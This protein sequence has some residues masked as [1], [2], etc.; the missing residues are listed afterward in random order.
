MMD[1]R[2]F[3]AW[4]MAVYWAL[5]GVKD[6]QLILRLIQEPLGVGN[7][8][9]V[10]GGAVATVVIAGLDVGGVPGA[11]VVGGDG[12]GAQVLGNHVLVPPCP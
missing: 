6:C 1:C 11:G 12:G 7:V 8:G 2:L 5:T 10:R 3:M 4:R 9:V